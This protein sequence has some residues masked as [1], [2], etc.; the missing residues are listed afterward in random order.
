MSCEGSVYWS[1]Y[2]YS[3]LFILSRACT[4]SVVCLLEPQKSFFNSGGGG[5]GGGG[6]GGMHLVIQVHCS[7]WLFQRVYLALFPFISCLCTFF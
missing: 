4:Y 5:R 1:T 3:H 7:Q 2:V 6:G